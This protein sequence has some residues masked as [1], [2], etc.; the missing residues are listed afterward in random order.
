MYTKRIQIVNYGPVDQLDITLPLDGDNPKPVVLVGENGSGKSI[1][2]SHIVN[3]LTA[4]KDLVY[5]DTTEVNRGKVYKLRSGYY[6]K[7]GRQ[8][9]FARVDFENDLFVE[10]MRTLQPKQESSAIP[11]GLTTEDA[12]AAWSRMKAEENDHFHPTISSLDRER[13]RQVE[14][15]FSQNCVL[16][17]P[18]NR[19]E[20]PAW[21]NEDNLK[22]KARHMNLK[23]LKGHTDRTIISYSPLRNNENWLFDVAYDFSVFELQT[24]HIAV[25]VKGPGTSK[26]TVSLP[27]FAG[28][29]GRAKSVYDIALRVVQAI[30]PGSNIRFG[31]GARSQRVVSVMESE[32]TRVHNIFQLSSGEVSLLNLFLSILRDFDLSGASFDKAED[33]RGI[34]IVDEI[35]LHLHA[36]HQNAILPDLIRMFPKVQF[37]VTTHSPLFV[38]GM[39]NSFGEGGFALYRLPQG[40]QISPEEFSEFE[41]AYKSF[42]T[43]SKFADDVR[44]AIQHAQKPI[45]FLE[46]DTDVKYLRRAAELLDQDS[47]L[48]KVDLK[49]GQGASNLRGGW[50][51]CKKLPTEMRPQKVLLLFDCDQQDP[52]DSDDGT[53]SKRTIP[54]QTDHPILTG[55]EN[56]FNGRTLEK[57]QTYKAAFIDIVHEHTETER[58]DKKTV[59]EIWTVNPDEK[60]NLCNWLCKNG[61]DEDFEFFRVIFDILQKTPNLVLQTSL[62]D[63]P[64]EE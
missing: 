29:S 41:N 34:A 45:I 61:T 3:G 52:G 64:Q 9:Y 16:Y 19:F 62:V 23:H 22:A 10:E 24:H 47:V 54:L 14:S 37:I 55:I 39:K 53:L 32:Q 58:G 31:I 8:F 33:I 46:G 12:K 48:E 59:P 40:Q 7:T 42:A 51:A 1:L 18:P 28:F 49:D 30:I 63:L 20:D 27:F 17:F 5:P 25:P 13:S 36:I 57:A 15:V 21:L 26:Q 56:L 4:A 38:L 44:T 35:D 11:D 60:A 43:T 50:K 2:L 6:I